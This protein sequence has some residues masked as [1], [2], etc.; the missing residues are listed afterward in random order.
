MNE[1][2]NIDDILK[3]SDIIEMLQGKKEYAEKIAK[4]NTRSDGTARK[5]KSLAV[6]SANFH[7]GAIDTVERWIETLIE[8]KKEKTNEN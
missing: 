3:A 7:W 2:K 8:N 6:S 4:E 1:F 5:G